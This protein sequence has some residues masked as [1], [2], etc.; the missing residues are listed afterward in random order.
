MPIEFGPEPADYAPLKTSPLDLLHKALGARMVAFAGWS[1][2]VQ[3][4]AGVLAEHL[5]CRA[6]GGAALFD[7][8]HMGQA[9]LHG[10]RRA[11]RRWRRWCPATSRASSPAGSATPC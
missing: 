8:S 3:Y 1:M 7:V 10:S 9:S 6:D 4:S 2:P 11:R 5:H